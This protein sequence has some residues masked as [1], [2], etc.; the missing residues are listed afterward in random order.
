MDY[1]TIPGVELVS[2]GMNWPSAS[3]DITI[4]FDHLR[5]AMIA[6]NEDPHVVPPRLKIGHV[7]PR[8]S[9]PDD[10]GH[11]PFYDGEPAVGSVHNLR[12]TNDGATLVG[13]Y[14]EVP[15]WLAEALPSAYPSRS[16]E[17]AYQPPE[18][19]LAKADGR[20]DVTTPGGKRYSFV[21]TACALLGVQRPAVQDLDDLQRFLV[22]GEGL[23]VAGTAP[24]GGQPA[25]ATLSDVPEAKGQKV[26]LTAS[27]DKVIEAFQS[28]VAEGE[29]VW[30]WVRDLLTEPNE[31][32]A[33][34][35][36]GNL[37]LVPFSSDG[38]QAITFDDPRRAL[39]VFVDAPAAAVRAA[40]SLHPKGSRVLASFKSREEIPGIKPKTASADGGTDDPARN[41]SMDRNTFLRQSLSLPADA[42]DEQIDAAL[43]EREDEPQTPPA[44]TG[45]EGEGDGAT[46]ENGGDG[47]EV[48]QPQTP[49][50][51]PTPDSEPGDGGEAGKG[52]GGEGADASEMI[53]VPR[54]AWQEVQRNSQAGAA[55]A[56]EAEITRRDDTIKL[57][58]SKGKM[59]P[60]QRQSMVN[61]HE[62]D[63]KA[64]Y[65][66]LT[67]AP[68]KGGLAENIVPVN[69]GGLGGDGPAAAAEVSDDFMERAFPGHVQAGEAV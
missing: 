32:V 38:D 31:I 63:A 9:D 26:T 25:A 22:A 6:A 21:L 19:A 49:P 23:V 37:F 54:S 67:E 33:D 40:Q 18:E 11:N 39:Q 69:P 34:D 62:K 28:T 7:D 12:L 20:W 52:D 10:P 51:P 30:W 46:E 2:V 43:A 64:F 53:S 66:L 50:A 65:V 5:D 44:E 68:E 45:K 58:C 17:G 14:V 56:A 29:R 24:E 61:L 35:D 42:S 16:I 4:R 47:S 3:G 36:E 59:T 57:A 15:A 41:L 27:V 8:F 60:A 55:L 1:V 48:T 13:D